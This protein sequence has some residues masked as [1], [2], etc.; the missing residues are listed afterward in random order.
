MTN[1]MR[2]TQAEQEKPLQKNEVAIDVWLR[3]YLLDALVARS[4]KRLTQ[5][6]IGDITAEVT[7]KIQLR[8]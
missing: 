4:G 8:L 3:V 5:D 6:L 7:H 2:D 1:D